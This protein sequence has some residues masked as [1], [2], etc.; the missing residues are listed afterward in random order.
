M[1]PIL[2]LIDED[3]KK[4]YFAA[5]V[6]NRLRELTY[7]LCFDSTVELLDK[8]SADAIKVYETTLRY[9]IAMA[10]HNVYPDYQIRISYNIFPNETPDVLSGVCSI[11]LF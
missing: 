4:N 11:V 6:N 1:S 3:K 9:I 8:T 5:K 10:F 7:E 2:D